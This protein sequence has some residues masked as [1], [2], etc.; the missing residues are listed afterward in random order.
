MSNLFEEMLL[1][2]SPSQKKIQ[3]QLSPPVAMTIAGSDSGGGAGL[4]ADLKTFAALACHGV[5]ATTLITAQNTQTVSLIQVL[6]FPLIRAQLDALVSDFDIRAT[7]CGAL[8]D[9][10][11]IAQLVEWLEDHPQPFLLVDPVMVSKHG[12]P[13]LP[14]Q[15]IKIMRQAL[16]PHATLLTP[17][18][19]EARLLT[20]RDVGDLHSMKEAAK[21][22]FDMG[23]PHILIK[24]PHLGRVVRDLYYDGTGFVE[25]GDDHI[26]SIRTHGSGCVFSAAITA[27]LAHH[28]PLLDAI[29]FAR[30]FI[31][32]AI[33]HAPSLG[34]G[35]PPV[36][37]LHP[38]W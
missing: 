35:I 25:F 15:S 32:Q 20:G 5:S 17:N 38:F 36:H 31:S 13:L 9:S 21:R 18:R 2:L 37:P 16:L 3:R 19:H 12:D 11:T 34:H 27:K 29:E 8:G 4:Q 33:L 24:G 1:D 10:T 23:P 6:P 14:D 26:D 7:K 28:T 30:T 22:L